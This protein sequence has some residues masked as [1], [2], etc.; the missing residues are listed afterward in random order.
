VAEWLRRGLQNLL[1]RFNSGRRLQRRYTKAYGK[2]KSYRS[3]F[4]IYLKLIPVGD[5]YNQAKKRITE[6]E[7]STED[8][9]GTGWNIG[10]SFYRPKQAI[11]PLLTDR[12]TIQSHKLKNKLFI[13][14]IKKPKCELCG[15]AEKSIDDRV[16]VELDHINGKRDDNR[17][18]NLR[19]LCPNC[20][21]L[22]TT[23]RG[24]NK[25]VFRARVME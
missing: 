18:E 4:I 22:K 23:H 7:L 21:S 24:K 2:L 6:L 13:E 1:H 9:T 3:V 12:N 5:N 16:P 11:E 19:I 10:Q 25:K 8:F 15:W 14:G 17:L 20:H